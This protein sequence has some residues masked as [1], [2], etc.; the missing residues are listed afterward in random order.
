MMF[1][2]WV[3]VGIL[4]LLWWTVSNIIGAVDGLSRL[5]TEMQRSLEKIGRTLDSIESNT[6]QRR[7]VIYSDLYGPL[8]EAGERVATPQELDAML[9][10]LAEQQAARVEKP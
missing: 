1:F 3:V 9:K 5:T 6:Q 10:E 8:P 7:S 4:A 2:E